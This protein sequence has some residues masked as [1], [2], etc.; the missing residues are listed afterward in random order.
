MQRALV[1]AEAAAAKAA[2]VR[3]LLSD[4]P[5]DSRL[6][7]ALAGM[8]GAFRPL[9]RLSGNK[10]YYLAREIWKRTRSGVSI[11]KAGG[12]IADEHEIS[13]RTV[14]RAW[15]KYKILAWIQFRPED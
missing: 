2:L 5:L 4:A 14:W 1:G 3:L 6:R 11:E 8:F 12:Q 7:S 15:A 13:D 9:P 10:D